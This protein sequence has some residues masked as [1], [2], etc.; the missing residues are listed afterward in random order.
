[1]RKTFLET[2]YNLAKDHP[3]IVLI[4]GDVG[5]GMIEKFAHDYPKQ[6]INAG[7]AEQNMTGVAT[8]L[9]LEGKIVF[10]YS[11]G[12]FPTLRCLEQIRSDVCYHDVNVKIVSVGGGLSYG[13]LGPSHHAVEDLAIMRTFPM[14]VVAP[15]DNWETAK[16][17]TAIIEHQGP[18][19]L[20]LEK[21]TPQSHIVARDS[22]EIGKG[23]I[24]KDGKDISLIAVGGILEEAMEASEQLLKN[25]IECRVISMYSIKPIDKNLIIDCALNTGGII[26]LEEHVLEG[27][28]GS[29]VEEVCMDAQTFPEKFL[30]MALTHNFPSVVGSQK[31]LRHYYKINSENIISN[32]LNLYGNI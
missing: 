13:A 14:S 20:R 8:G 24:L 7:I 16:A 5:Y 21:D 1:M 29:A 19:Y 2:L 12:N 23:R 30:R 10:T 9:A 28:L 26:T 4:T 15:A 3:E 27:G 6:F 18:A 31:Y 17:T 25:N 22:F 11:I 32:V